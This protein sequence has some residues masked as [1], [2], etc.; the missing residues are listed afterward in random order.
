MIGSG[1]SHLLTVKGMAA[2]PQRA[3][4]VQNRTICARFL[5]RQITVSAVQSRRSGAFLRWLTSRQVPA[6]CDM[7]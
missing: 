2:K 6:V 4:A 1:T 7:E 5:T 3:R